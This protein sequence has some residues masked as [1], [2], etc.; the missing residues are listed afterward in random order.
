[1]FVLLALLAGLLAGCAGAPEPGG[2]LAPV[3]AQD[4]L[5]YAG[6]RAIEVRGLNY[7][8]PSDADL[9]TCSA[10]QFGADA[11]CPWDLGPIAAD[12]ERL[13]KAAM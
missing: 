9:A 2:P 5:L 4:G 1:M 6:G 10:I 12:F 8:H 7:I 11:N 3:R 13:F